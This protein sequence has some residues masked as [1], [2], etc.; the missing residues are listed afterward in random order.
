MKKQF[1]KKLLRCG[2]CGMDFYTWKGYEDQGQDRGYGI[3]SEC[4]EIAEDR[5]NEMVNDAFDKIVNSL[6]EKNKKEAKKITSIAIKR[7]L[8][9]KAIDNNMLEW[10]IGK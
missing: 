10:K 9:A 6:S 7:K 4:Q 8:V 1:Q 5:E 2:C 3:C